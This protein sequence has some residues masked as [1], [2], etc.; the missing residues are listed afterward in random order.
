MDENKSNKEYEEEIIKEFVDQQFIQSCMTDVDPADFD[1]SVAYE[2][3]MNAA[4]VEIPE[5]M[6]NFFQQYKCSTNIFDMETLH[7]SKSLKMKKYK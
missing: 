4:G 2:D 3:G 6:L 5:E 7:N 1:D